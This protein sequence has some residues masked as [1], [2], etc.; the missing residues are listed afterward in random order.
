MRK[1]TPEELREHQRRATL[2]RRKIRYDANTKS[3]IFGLPSAAT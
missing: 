1:M 2:A 3:G